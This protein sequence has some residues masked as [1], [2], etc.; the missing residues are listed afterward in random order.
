MVDMAEY[1]IVVKLCPCDQLRSTAAESCSLGRCIR[2]PAK[3]NMV[4]DLLTGVRTTRETNVISNN[5]CDESGKSSIRLIEMVAMVDSTT[6]I[7]LILIVLV[8]KAAIL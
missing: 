6:C 3:I 7:R 4:S 2:N 1:V 8:C 5:K